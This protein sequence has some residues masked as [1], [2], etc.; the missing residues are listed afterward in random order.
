VLPFNELYIGECENCGADLEDWNWLVDDMVF[1]T[2][3]TCGAEYCLEPTTGIL[4]NEIDNTD[5]EDLEE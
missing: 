5:D 4:T 2:N 1:R 3:C